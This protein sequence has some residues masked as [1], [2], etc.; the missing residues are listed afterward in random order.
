MCQQA[1]TATTMAVVVRP[2]PLRQL[3][4]KPVSGSLER[5]ARMASSSR[6]KSCGD[7]TTVRVQGC[8]WL[9]PTQMVTPVFCVHVPHPTHN[10][11]PIHTGPH[12]CEKL[13]A[14][15][16]MSPSQAPRTGHM[17]R[18]NTLLGL[19]MPTLHLAGHAQVFSSQQPSPCLGRNHVLPELIQTL[20]EQPSGGSMPPAVSPR[21]A[22]QAEGNNPK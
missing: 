17:S 11:V 9:T 1:R 18:H 13:H 8:H 2:W 4:T 14:F 10:L 16:C 5:A 6:S 12:I 20:R 19:N 22:T 21:T 3:K 7:E 15:L